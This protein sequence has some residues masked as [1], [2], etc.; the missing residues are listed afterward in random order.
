MCHVSAHHVRALGRGICC[1]IQTEVSFL[2]AQL[3]SLSHGGHGVLEDQLGPGRLVGH[4]IRAEFFDDKVVAE[5]IQTAVDVGETHGQLQEQDDVLLGSALHDKAI[6]HQ[7]LQEETQ[8]D[9]EKGDHKDSQTGRDSPDT[10]LL[11]DPVLGVVLTGDQNADV[12]VGAEAH[13]AH[14]E[15]EA[16]DLKRE[17]D[18]G[19]PGAIRH[20]VEA[21]VIFHFPMEAVDRGAPHPH[22][23]PD[24]A[25]DPKGLPG[26]PEV[27][28]QERV[29]DGQESVQA[30]EA[31]SEDAPIHADEVEA[32]H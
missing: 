6:P 27:A 19:T 24:G 11:L 16:E 29:P 30:D 18:L 15:E 23:D 22:Q 2:Q 31:D 32:L 4:H 13:D 14:G 9:G 1:G 28:D 8:V 17:E 7:E 3:S 21:P 25:A 10:G 5:N 26:G 20:V 12:P